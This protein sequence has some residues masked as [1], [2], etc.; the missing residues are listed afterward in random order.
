MGAWDALDNP[1]CEGALRRR[2]G[3]HTAPYYAYDHGAKV[4][5]GE[6][7]PT[8]TSSISGLDFYDG[9]TFP[10][11]YDGALFFADYARRCAW[12]MLARR[13]RAARPGADPHRSSPT[14]PVVDLQVGPGGDLFY[15]DLGGSRAPRAGD[16]RQPGADAR[17]SP[18]TPDRGPLPLTVALDG[19]GSTDPDGTPLSLRL[20]HRPR[21]R[22]RRRHAARSSTRAFTASGT[23]PGAAAG[24]ATRAVSPTSPR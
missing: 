8:G 20:G 2:R 13:Q 10:A 3:A 11:E 6:T 19:R 1:V 7:C 12:A 18:R 15:V 5:A 24:D 23:V 22:V 21:R 16:D 4:V 9:G 14:R 17:A